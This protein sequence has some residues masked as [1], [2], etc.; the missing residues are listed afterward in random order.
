[1]P[2]RGRGERRG[3]R[4]PRG[5]TRARPTRRARG[6]GEPVRELGERRGPGVRQGVLLLHGDG[7]DE[8]GMA[9]LGV[10]LIWRMVASSQGTLDRATLVNKNTLSTFPRHIPSFS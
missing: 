2:L 5:G 6:G 1:V 4:G 8:L 10:K 9:A 3:R 7:G